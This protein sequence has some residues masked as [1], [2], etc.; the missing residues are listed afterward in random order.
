MKANKKF[1]TLLII[2]ISILVLWSF[3]GTNPFFATVSTL[4][5]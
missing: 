1:L 4:G 5:F 2:T 3:F